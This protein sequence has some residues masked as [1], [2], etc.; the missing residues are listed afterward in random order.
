MQNNL[1]LMSTYSYL[2]VNLVKGDGS[3]LFDDKGNKYIDFTSGIGVNSLG[4]GNPDWVKAITDA[5]GNLQHIS[6]IFLNSTTLKLA[7]E[8][9]TKTN[10]CKVFFSNS[11]A[12]ANEG[13][14]KLAR[15]YSFDKYGLNRNKVLTLN[16]SFHG[17]TL[18]A[19]TATGQDKFHNYFFP[20][21]EGFDY[22]EA[23]NIT[24]FKNK[25]SSDVC[26]VMMEAIQGEGGVNP[27]NKDFVDE[28][29]KICKENDIILI[30]DEVQ[31]GIGRTGKV[32]GFQHFH[33]QPDIV[34]M[35]KGLG[36]GLPIGGLLCNKKLSEV[37]NPGD[38]GTTFGGNPVACSGAL[39]V[40]DKICNEDMLN[41]IKEKGEYLMQLLKDI[42]SPLIKDIRGKGLMI[43]V[44][45][46]TTPSEIQKKALEKGLLVLTAGKNV[47]RLLPPLIISKE[48]I[49]EGIKILQETIVSM[50]NV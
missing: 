22:F 29:Y 30:F 26:A 14:I 35:A 48:E 1:P 46:A 3:Y 2:P 49:K 25:L 10:M 7:E 21:P 39:V 38:H 31:C 45:V 20:F 37:F 15:K 19:L 42:N 34:T 47:I 41:E 13:A 6:N 27:L 23:N 28:V 9:I 33:I 18:A 32:F 16:N 17:R 50:H 24:D 8:L 44:E 5:A 40:L 11:G 43:G 12:E 36:A 4:Y